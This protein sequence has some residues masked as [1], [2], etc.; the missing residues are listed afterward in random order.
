MAKT[1]DMFLAELPDVE[2]RAIHAEAERLIAE[3]MTLRDLRDVLGHSQQEVG[4]AMNVNQAAVSKLERR[5]DMRISTL[6]EF[7]QAMGGELDIM[8]RM[9]GGNQVHL[10]QF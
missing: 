6:R 1:L 7:V 10:K 4:E 9:P 3:E 2:Q 8:V 5:S